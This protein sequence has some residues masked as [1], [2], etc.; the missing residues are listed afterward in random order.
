MATWLSVGNSYPPVRYFKACPYCMKDILVF[1]SIHMG[2]LKEKNFYSFLLNIQMTHQLMSFHQGPGG[3]LCDLT[4]FH[5]SEMGVT[6]KKNHPGDYGY[7]NTLCI[8]I[9]EFYWAEMSTPVIAYFACRRGHYPS[10]RRVLFF[11]WLRLVSKQ[12]VEERVY[13]SFQAIQSTMTRSWGR[14]SRQGLGG[15]T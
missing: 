2:L 11:F 1:V 4:F 6:I 14:R 3:F 10:F 12:P 15:R 5:L 7:S 13:S 9:F 8:R